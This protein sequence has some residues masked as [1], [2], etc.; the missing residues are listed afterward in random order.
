MQ[1]TFQR[2]ELANNGHVVLSKSSA[3]SQEMLM[4]NLQ[5]HVKDAVWGPLQQGRGQNQL[6]KF[7]VTDTCAPPEDMTS[8]K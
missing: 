1:S 7:K 6:S 2:S 3:A 8:G 4:Q 5:N